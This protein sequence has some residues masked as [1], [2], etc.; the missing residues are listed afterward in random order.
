MGRGA[1]SVLAES[2]QEPSRFFAGQLVHWSR[3]TPGEVEPAIAAYQLYWATLSK[4]R[5]IGADDRV[6]PD[7]LKKLDAKIMDSRSEALKLLSPLIESG[8]RVREGRRLMPD[9][10]LPPPHTATLLADWQA[11][12]AIELCLASFAASV[13]GLCVCRG[14]T[15]VFAPKRKS[16]ARYCPLCSKRP[17]APPLGTVLPDGL[18]P[19]ERWRR[20]QSVRVRVPAWHGDE[21]APWRVATIGLSSE[22]GEVFVGR[23]DKKGT[24]ADRKRRARRAA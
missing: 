21:P 15:L 23:S 17:A 16:Q 2:P 9:A 20:G 7:Q 19:G 10:V 4:R 14:C 22:T 8:L 12:K 18:K 6:P 11:W 3:R 13:R 5:R 1:Q 24:A